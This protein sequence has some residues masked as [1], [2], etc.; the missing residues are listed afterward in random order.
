MAI[1]LYHDGS[2]RLW[3]IRLEQA[4]NNRSLGDADA[5]CAEAG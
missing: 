4:R 2:D 1:V 5:S 3:G